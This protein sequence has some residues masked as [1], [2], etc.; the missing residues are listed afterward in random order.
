MKW[1]ITNGN[2]NSYGN[3]RHDDDDD[4]DSHDNN[5]HDN[6]IHG[7]NSYEYLQNQGFIHQHGKTLLQHDHIMQAVL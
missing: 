3:N 5:S 4:N 2:N 1:W 6:N 7:N